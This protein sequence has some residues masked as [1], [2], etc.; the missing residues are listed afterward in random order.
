SWTA[1]LLDSPTDVR[2]FAKSL[3]SNF[4]GASLRSLESRVVRPGPLVEAQL[5]TFA[6]E[7]TLGRDAFAQELRSVMSSFTKFSTADFQITS[8]RAE[9][10]EPV[11]TPG[12]VKT[13]I[14]YE[15]VG[16]TQGF[17][18]EQR[19]GYWDLEWQATGAGDFQ[20]RTWQTLNETVSRAAEPVFADIT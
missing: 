11:K 5:R 7:H 9:N 20:V 4:S 2:S 10:V 13:L 12:R 6:A 1:G 15:L 19:V 8:I 17:I 3:S 14:M 18:R 16:S